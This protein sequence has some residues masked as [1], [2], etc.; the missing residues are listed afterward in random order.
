MSS[1]FSEPAVPVH[2]VEYNV[3]SKVKRNQILCNCSRAVDTKA[4]DKKV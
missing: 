1:K 4:V 3:R 2:V